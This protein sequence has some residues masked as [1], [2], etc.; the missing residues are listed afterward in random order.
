[1]IDHGLQTMF[2]NY[3]GAFTEPS[4]D[5]REQLMR[6]SVAEDVVFSNPGASG[7]GLNDLL[8]HISL[9]QERFPGSRF[10]INWSRQ[11]H[12]QI[13]AEWTQ[14]NQ[15]SSEFITAHS[16]ARLNDEGRIGHFAGFWQ[17]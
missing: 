10:R 3:L 1:M 6:S 8:T 12:G 14:F 9:F 7:R 16:Y 11:Q 5:M 17:Q 4:V 13:L 15:D 2:E